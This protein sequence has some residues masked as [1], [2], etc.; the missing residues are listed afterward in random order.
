MTNRGGGEPTT[1]MA[2]APRSRMDPPPRSSAADAYDCIMVPIRLDRPNTSLWRD[3]SRQ[4]RAPL[5]SSPR[6][7]HDRR[8]PD[9]SPNPAKSGP[10][11]QAS[12]LKAHVLAAVKTASRAPSAV[13][14]ASLR[15]VSTAAAQGASLNPGRDGETVH[16]SNKETGPQ[17]GALD[18][19]SEPL[20]KRDSHD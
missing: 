9:A 1:D 17:E 2:F 5:G 11:G 8:F 14:V 19:L 12:G 3:R 15:P 13:A 16:R 7:R 20:G 18:R 10:T 6:Q 4:W